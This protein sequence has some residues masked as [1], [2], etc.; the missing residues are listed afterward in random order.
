MANQL[1]IK[2]GTG[3]DGT[4][5]RARGDVGI[6]DGHIT[7]IGATSTA[8]RLDAVTASSRRGSSTSTH[9]DAQVFGTLPRRRASRRHH[10]VAATAVPIAPTPS[11]RS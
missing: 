7:E 11:T 2:G 6:A 3:H 9:Y 1:V 8:S 5:Q 4:A 10:R